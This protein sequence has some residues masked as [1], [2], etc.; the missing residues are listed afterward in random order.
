MSEKNPTLSDVQGLLKAAV[1][2]NLKHEAAQKVARA[3]W[4]EFAEIRS[5]LRELIGARGGNPVAFAHDGVHMVAFINDWDS[6]EIKPVCSPA[7]L[8]TGEP[9]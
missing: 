7:D 3:A 5:E 2:A 6:L 8:A 4:E 1:E 9:L